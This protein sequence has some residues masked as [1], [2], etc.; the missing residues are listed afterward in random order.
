M[1]AERSFLEGNLQCDGREIILQNLFFL[2]V[3]DCDPV[4]NRWV[5]T[6]DA[7]KCRKSIKAHA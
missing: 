1:P 4:S 2:G 5:A 6:S 3:S 7:F